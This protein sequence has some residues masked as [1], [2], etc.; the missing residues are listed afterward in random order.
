[1]VT[2]SDNSVISLQHKKLRVGIQLWASQCQ[3]WNS[4]WPSKNRTDDRHHP[5]NKHFNQAD[6]H[7]KQVIQAPNNILKIHT[8]HKAWMHVNKH[9]YQHRWG[10]TKRCKKGINWETVA[11]F[12]SSSKCVNENLAKEYQSVHPPCHAMDKG[13]L[14]VQSTPFIQLQSIIHPCWASTSLNIKLHVNSELYKSEHLIGQTL[15]E[16]LE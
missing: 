14:G 10:V 3:T 11:C 5:V 7:H 4:T 1:M 15:H 13:R 8:L 2:L 16:G 6:R 12:P 9:I